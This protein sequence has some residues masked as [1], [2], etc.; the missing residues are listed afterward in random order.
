MNEVHH[1]IEVKVLTGKNIFLRFSNGKSG[2]FNFD[3]FF[4]YIGIFEPLK[5]Q[6]YFEKVSVS[7][8]TITWPN[9]CDLCPDVLYSIVMGEKIYHDG[10]LVFDPTLGKKAWIGRD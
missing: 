9:D 2:S 7:E 5:D 3:D 10:N 6:A 1:I 4:N 8:G